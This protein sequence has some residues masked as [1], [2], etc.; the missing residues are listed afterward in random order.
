[1]RRTLAA[2]LFALSVFP[3]AARAGIVQG[4]LKVA[5][6]ADADRTVVYLEGVPAGAVP[7]AKLARLSQ[8]GARFSPS[9]LPVV[10]G[11]TVDLTNDD[12]VSHSVFS[13]SQPKPFDLGL[14]SKGERRVVT[15][16]KTGVIEVFCAIHPRMNAVVLVLDNG[17]YT[18]PSAEGQFSL[19][20]VPA[21]TYQVHLY[22][23]GGQ[24]AARPVIVPARGPV[25]VQF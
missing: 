12:W 9:L 6:A 8:K 23:L 2:S 7:D 20:E 1:M 15:F 25:D 11:T 18:K 24:T 14:Y 17:F 16:D 4:Q 10:K 3:A 22:R 13:K 5:G 19:G 21:G